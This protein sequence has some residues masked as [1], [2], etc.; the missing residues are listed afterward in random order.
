MSVWKEGRE[1]LTRRVSP[2]RLPEATY[3]S[4]QNFKRCGNT[5]IVLRQRNELLG[6]GY[7]MKCYDKGIDTRRARL[8]KAEVLERKK[9]VIFMLEKGMGYKEIARELSL[10]PSTMWAYVKRME[11]K[12]EVVIKQPMIK[13]TGKAGR[14]P[15]N[16][17]HKSHYG[18][19]KII[20]FSKA[21]K[22]TDKRK[23]N[24]GDRI[25]LDYK[26][27]SRGQLAKDHSGH[28]SIILKTEYRVVKS[29]ITARFMYL[30]QCTDCKDSKPDW[31]Y[32]RSFNKINNSND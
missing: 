32:S 20:P 12:G 26:D 18:F 25:K 16:V 31:A 8:T 15:A 28:E 6:N 24:V 10:L 13:T 14:K 3:G 23:A 19:D 21:L 17:S 1:G 5:E 7:C 4:C 11:S 9:D 29:S 22:R 2:V 30:I 27:K